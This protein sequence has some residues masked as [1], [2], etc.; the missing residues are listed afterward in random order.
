MEKELMEIDEQI[1]KL[2]E[3]KKATAKKLKEKKERESLERLSKIESF[4]ENHFGE[5]TEEKW[6]VILKFISKNENEIISQFTDFENENEKSKTKN[7][8]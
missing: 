4:L 1:K 6:N 2:K 7:E 5:I 8:N 3:K